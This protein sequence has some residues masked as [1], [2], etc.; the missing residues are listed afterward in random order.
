MFIHPGLGVY[1]PAQIQQMIIQT[2]QDKGV[3]PNLALAVA[4]HES[5][6]VVDATNY[7]PATASRPASTD[8]GVFQLN[9][10]TISQM[11]VTNP[12]DAQ[13]NIDAGVSLLKQYSNQYNGDLNTILWAYSAGPGSV[14][15]GTPPASLPSYVAAVSSYMDSTAPSLTGDYSGVSTGDVT[16]SDPSTDGTDSGVPMGVVIG[17]AAIAG[18][19]LWALFRG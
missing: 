18:L 13:Q 14:Q 9:D 4:N 1:S 11:G 10:S 8:W 7:N 2:A 5:G 15:K 17:G 6:F 16:T 12:F 3:D 19:A